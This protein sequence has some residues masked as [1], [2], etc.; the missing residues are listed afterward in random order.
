MP[1]AP[2]EIRTFF[3]TAGAWDRRPIFRAQPSVGGPGKD[4]QAQTISKSGAPF[5]RSLSG[6]PDERLHSFFF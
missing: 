2:Q 5:K 3:I 1:L 6:A 4:P